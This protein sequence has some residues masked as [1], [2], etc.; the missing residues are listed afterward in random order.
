MMRVRSCAYIEEQGRILTLVYD[1]PNGR[2]YGLPGGGVDEGE[3]AGQAVVR[4]CREELGIEI[5]LGALRYV[6]D[7]LPREGCSKQ[8]LHLVFGAKRLAG[9]PRLDPSHTTAAA[10]FWLPLEELS[11]ATLY[12]AVSQALLQDQESGEQARYLGA[13]LTRDWL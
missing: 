6:G 7:M 3:T 10:L 4:E 5:E 12:P 1:Y 2:V 11:R 13:S 8:T 9:E